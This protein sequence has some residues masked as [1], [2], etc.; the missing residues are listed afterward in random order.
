MNI[1]KN[2]LVTPIFKKQLDDS[3]NIYK[4]LI[5]DGITLNLVKKTFSIYNF[6]NDSSNDPS[7]IINIPSDQNSSLISKLTY[8]YDIL[9]NEINNLQTSKNLQ[10][11][12][13]YITTVNSILHDNIIFSIITFKF[14]HI[15]KGLNLTV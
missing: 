1:Y 5:T 4:K 14:K 9:K 7:Y 12:D 8:E 6:L 13:N 2:I 3:D 15:F 11:I 10:D